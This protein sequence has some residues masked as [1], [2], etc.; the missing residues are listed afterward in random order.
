[1]SQSINEWSSAVPAYPRLE[2]RVTESGWTALDADAERV[3]QTPPTE[4]LWSENFL[5][6]L[7]DN[8]HNIGMWLHLGTVPTDWPLWEDRI[9]VTLPDRGVISMM[10]YHAT[11]VEHRPAGSV[12][13]F[14]CVEPFRRWQ[15]NF[16]GFAW[17]TSEAAME[18]GGEPRYR[19]RVKIALEVECVSPVWD[20][21]ATAGSSG[22]TGMLGQSWAKEHYEQLVRASGE[23]TVDDV[24]Y[25]LTTTG[26]RDHSRGPRGRKS[27]DP[28][29]GHVIGGCQF[30]S[31]K[32]FMFSRYWRPDGVVS[33]AGGMFVDEAGESKAVS[34]SDA[35][36]L[37]ELVLRGERLPIHL[38]W[39]GGE[40]VT[41]METQASIWIPRERKHVVGRDHHG[42][43]ND[44]YV[45][46]WGPVEWDS[47]TGYMYLERSAHLNA[48]PGAIG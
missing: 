9:Y 44:M 46:N 11:A 32:Q 30:P 19:R 31:G 23:M 35:P 22:Q 41:T 6:A 36:Q 1:M 2:S 12:M 14:Q 24:S 27:K 48:L 13:A 38:Q 25:D 39:E 28:W 15:I 45:L 37:R 21:R 42:E 47:E 34:V 26:W 5:F 20:A 29:G 18:A 43:L 33:M 40:V 7:Y 8:R 17:Y 16:D 4:P 3:V 10:A